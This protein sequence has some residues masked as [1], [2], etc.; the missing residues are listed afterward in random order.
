VLERHELE[1]Q[2]RRHPARLVGAD[3]YVVN[4]RGSKIDDD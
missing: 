2:P 4:A 3:W 1:Y